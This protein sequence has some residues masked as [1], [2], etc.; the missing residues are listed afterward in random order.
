MFQLES[1]GCDLGRLKAQ[2]ILVVVGFLSLARRHQFQK[3][4]HILLDWWSNFSRSTHLIPASNQYAV[5]FSMYI[6]KDKFSEKFYLCKNFPSIYL[7][8]HLNIYYFFTDFVLCI[9]VS[10]VHASKH[11]RASYLVGKLCFSKCWCSWERGLICLH[12]CNSHR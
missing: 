11:H 12:I 2:G 5:Q 1:S 6:K 10:V 7:H 4:Q 3:Q 9:T 8:T